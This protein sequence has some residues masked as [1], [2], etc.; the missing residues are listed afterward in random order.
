MRLFNEERG[1]A[2]VIFAISLTAIVSVA[3]L[4]LDVG[5]ARMVQAEQAAALDAAAT[6]GAQAVVP[7]TDSSGNPYLTINT[8]E[9]QAMADQVYQ[10]N[11]TSMDK[12]GAAWTPGALNVQVTQGPGGCTVST[13][14]T[15]QVQTFFSGAVGW[16]SSIAVH[17]TSTAHPH[18]LGVPCQ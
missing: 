2:A 18:S 17:G 16:A 6:A 4:A 13:S 9:A 10:A 15:A 3:A 11:I 12:P 14:A 7:E 8:T 5:R 1:Q